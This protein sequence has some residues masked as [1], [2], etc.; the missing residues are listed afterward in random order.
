M[1]AK[2][3]KLQEVDVRLLLLCSVSWA[4]DITVSNDLL[5]H[6]TKQVCTN[7]CPVLN[8]YKVITTSD[9]GQKVWIT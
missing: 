5:T 6:L 1:Q 2:L 7:M 9:L 8:G 3:C 4:V